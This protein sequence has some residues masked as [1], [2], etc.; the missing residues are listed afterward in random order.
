MT[1]KRGPSRMTVV[2]PYHRLLDEAIG[3][4][5]VLEVARQWGVPAF[6]LYDGLREHVKAPSAKY[7]AAVAA[8]LGL[9]IDALL[10]KLQQPALPPRQE[11]APSPVAQAADGRKLS[12]HTT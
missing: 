4:R 1:T 5:S 12:A 10:I 6:L 7:L 8:G 11:E 2:S 9:T 3:E